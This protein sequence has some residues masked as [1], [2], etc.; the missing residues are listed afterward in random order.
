MSRFYP[1]K[2]HIMP[3][4]WGS[5]NAI[6][7]LLGKTPDPQQPQAE[8]WMGAHLKA[9]SNVLYEGSW[10]RLDDLIKQHPGEILGREVAEKFDGRLP[11]LFKVLAAAKPLSLQAHPSKKQ[12]QQGFD[13]ENRQGIALDDPI[14][15]YKDNNHKPECILALTTFWALNG[16]RNI[17]D[18]LDLFERLNLDDLEPFLKILHQ[19]PAEEA[20][21]KFFELLMKSSADKNKQLTQAAVSAA[22]RLRSTDPVYRWMLELAEA[23]PGD[24]GIFSP[25]F[26]NLICLEPGQA[27]FLP[28]GELHAYLEGVGIELMANSDNVLRGGLTP[29]HVDVPELLKVLNFKERSVK[30]LSPDPD[31]EGARLFSGEAEE[32]MLEQIQLRRDTPYE[33]KDNRSVEIILCTDGSATLTDT[34]NLKDLSLTKGASALIPAAI[35]NYLIAGQ[36][37]LFKASVPL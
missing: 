23:Y 35:K 21:K 10:I 3:Y 31:E 34:V 18:V 13:R 37:T 9:P 14:R 36:A 1:L 5:V 20:L 24:I 26:L 12:A 15:N 17:Q 8:L 27:M 4:A 19:H 32:F 25:I 30:I 7:E 16:F 22:A 6:P 11:Y 29:K 28:A 2:N 33:K